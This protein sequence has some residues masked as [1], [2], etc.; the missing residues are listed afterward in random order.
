MKKFGMV[1]AFLIFLIVALDATLFFYG[2]PKA[3]INQITSCTHYGAR[4]L[5]ATDSQIRIPYSLRDINFYLPFSPS[6]CDIHLKKYRGNA[7]DIGY[8]NATAGAYNIASENEGAGGLRNRRKNI[9]N[10][11]FLISKGL[12]VNAKTDYSK[13][14]KTNTDVKIQVTSLYLAVASHDLEAVQMLLDNGA[15]PNIKGG[16]MGLTPL[17]MAIKLEE[18]RQDPSYDST[19]DISG[20]IGILK[21]A[22]VVRNN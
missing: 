7:E 9:E 13:V 12:D 4:L 15:N 22:I 19:K 6:L 11:Q 16:I 8:L 14:L 20:V 18:A 1:L 2:L 5:S 21:E 10:L 3:K 17:E